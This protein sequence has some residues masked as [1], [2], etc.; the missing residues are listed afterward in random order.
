MS[1]LRNDETF[2]TCKDFGE[3]H[4]FGWGFFLQFS[5][6]HEMPGREGAI[7]GRD[8]GLNSFW[9]Q[10]RPEVRSQSGYWA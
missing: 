5:K 8:K 9:A 7:W 6:V 1:C 3:I 10:Y 4:Q 2:S